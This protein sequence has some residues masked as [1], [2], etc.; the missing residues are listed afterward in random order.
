VAPGAEEASKASAV[1]A[2]TIINSYS[3]GEFPVVAILQQPTLP[4]KQK[5]QQ[6]TSFFFY[7]CFSM[8]EARIE[9]DF[10]RI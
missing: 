1:Q 7:F 4:F 10:Y 5:K 9:T 2:E 6:G 3:K 8:M